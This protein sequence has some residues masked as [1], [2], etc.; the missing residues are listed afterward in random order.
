[1]D[2]VNSYGQE[3]KSLNKVITENYKKAVIGHDY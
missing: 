2:L 1:M 3:S